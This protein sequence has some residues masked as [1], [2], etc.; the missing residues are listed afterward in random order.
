M[1]DLQASLERMTKT[2]WDGRFTTRPATR[3]HSMLP[4]QF[5]FGE[6][7]EV[8]LNT[9]TGKSVFGIIQ[10]IHFT[11]SKISYDIAFKIEG[12][13]VYAVLTGFRG[14]MRAKGDKAMF[15]DLV[16]ASALSAEIDKAIE[17]GA[18]DATSAMDTSNTGTVHTLKP[19][20]KGIDQ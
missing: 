14:H 13:D 17:Q 5:K 1:I 16:S 8:L 20:T 18:L 6:E 12:S 11:A 7:V 10:A 3:E 15:E 4:S 19:R 2:Y 9:E